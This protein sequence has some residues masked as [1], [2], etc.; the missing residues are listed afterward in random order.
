MLSNVRVRLNLVPLELKLT[1][2]HDSP[3]LVLSHR[4]EP[5]T[6]PTIGVAPQ[7]RVLITRAG[8][9]VTV[10]HAARFDPDI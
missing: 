5:E 10:F 6:C 1:V 7:D 2:T 8:A 9:G 3:L 4:R